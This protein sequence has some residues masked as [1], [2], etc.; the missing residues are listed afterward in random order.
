[1]SKKTIIF[2]AVSALALLGALAFPALRFR[3]HPAR[4]LLLLSPVEGGSGVLDPQKLRRVAEEE[5]LLTY[6]VRQRLQV[7]TA[8]A[9]C[10]VTLIGTN[11]LYPAL[12]AY[13]MLRGGFFTGASEK[14]R[15]R[16]AVLNRAAAFRLFGGEAIEGRTIA[17]EGVPWLVTGVMDDGE[18]ESPRMYVP[19]ASAGEGPR[20]LLI[21]LGGGVD[22]AHVKNTLMPLGISETS[23][24]FFDLSRAIR[25]Y[26]ERFALALRVFICALFLTLARN[27]APALKARV[28][29]FRARLKYAYAG[30]LIVIVLREHTGKLFRFALTV[31]GLAGGAVFC[32]SL[33]PQIPALLLKWKDMPSLAA[34]LGKGDFPALSAPL[35]D[36]YYPDTLGFALCLGIS[37]LMPFLAGRTHSTGT[38]VAPEQA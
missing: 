16:E 33:L 36:Y 8:Y 37:V 27:R 19:A 28:S 13:P 24:V 5:F 30:E 23:H 11:S 35:L 7:W 20:S 12:M 10:P 4:N 34:I 6:E 26:G 15:N 22:A 18:E 14:G 1:L 38:G 2:L 29:A 3:G 9:E 31:L 21:L 32:L 17:M 25:L